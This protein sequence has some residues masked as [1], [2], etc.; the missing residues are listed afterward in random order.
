V[1]GNT[2]ERLLTGADFDP[3]SMQRAADGNI[4]SV[5]SLVTYYISQQKEFYWMH[6]LDCLI[7]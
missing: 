5:M 2:S 6:Q 4:G 7:L 3:E 1:N